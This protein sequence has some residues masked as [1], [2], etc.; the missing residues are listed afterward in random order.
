MPSSFIAFEGV[1]V[2]PITRCPAFLRCR[3]AAPPCHPVAPATTKVLGLSIQTCE[4][5]MKYDC[6]FNIM[7]GRHLI[8]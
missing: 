1:C 8:A 4:L 2:I 3:A 5:I 7:K 6:L